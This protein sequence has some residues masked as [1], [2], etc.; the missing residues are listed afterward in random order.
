MPVQFEQCDP[1]VPVRR[2]ERMKVN[3]S[4]LRIDCVVAA[5]A[6]VSRTVAAEMIAQNFAPFDEE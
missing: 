2:T 5:L 1:I 4:S 6:N 3:V